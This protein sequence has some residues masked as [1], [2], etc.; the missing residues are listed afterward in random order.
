[1]PKILPELATLKQ[2]PSSV[3]PLEYLLSH[4]EAIG[5]ASASVIGLTRAL[6]H[7]RPASFWK[8]SEMLH[9]HH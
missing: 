9:L 1:M 5:S 4:H 2:C 6:H 3:N 8:K 7:C